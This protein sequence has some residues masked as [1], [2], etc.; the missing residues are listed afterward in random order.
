MQSQKKILPHSGYLTFFWKFRYVEIMLYNGKSILSQYKNLPQIWNSVKEC[1]IYLFPKSWFW[2]CYIERRLIFL[3]SV[4]SKGRGRSYLSWSGK[5]VLGTYHYL[6]LSL[7]CQ[8]NNNLKW[9][10][11]LTC[12]LR[13][14]RILSIELKG[15]HLDDPDCCCV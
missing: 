12:T 3:D 11:A 14:L 7:I 9:W 4:R 6:I 5:S 8:I 10:H 13:G 2:G 1:S 15:S